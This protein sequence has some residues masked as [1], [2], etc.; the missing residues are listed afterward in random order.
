MATKLGTVKA[1]IIC[2]TPGNLTAPWILFE[3]GAIS[4][5]PEKAYVCTLLVDLQLTNR[6][7][8]CA[9]SVFN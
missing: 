6:A 5:T 8:R 9:F 3:A 2:L 7:G 4:K 1:G